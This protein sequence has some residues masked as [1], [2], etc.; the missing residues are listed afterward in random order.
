MRA[1]H[2]ISGLALILVFAGCGG[3]VTSRGV[4]QLRAIS[5]VSNPTRIDV[6]TDF[7]LIASDLTNGEGAGYSNQTATQ[8]TLGVREFG[9]TQTLASGNLDAAPGEK[10]T[11]LPHQTGNSTIGILAIA[12]NAT[13]PAA[14]KFKLRLVH[15]D[16]LVGGVD[17]YVVNPGADLSLETPV[18]ANVVFQKATAYVEL[19]AGIQKDIVITSTGTTNQL[20]NLISLTPAN[21]S[22][23]TLM[24]FDSSGPALTLYSD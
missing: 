22:I 20:G 17:V 1:K 7:N 23:R 24:F 6:F 8:L 11:I 3:S 2:L 15:V 4:A 5:A 18:L 19:T 16:R 9:E 13:T 12:D 21:G 14:G 10:F